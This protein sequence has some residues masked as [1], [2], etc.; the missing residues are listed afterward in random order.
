MCYG[1]SSYELRLLPNPL[2][3]Q[4]AACSLEVEAYYSGCSS[5]HNSDYSDY[6]GYLSNPGP[7]SDS[8]SDSS[9]C[10]DM[11]Y[12]HIVPAVVDFADSHTVLVLLSFVP[13]GNP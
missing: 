6:S 11:Y 13:T 5:S 7:D 8:D 4:V 9:T 1:K 12:L 2:S 10:S 3:S